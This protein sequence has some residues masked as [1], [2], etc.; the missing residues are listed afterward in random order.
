MEYGFKCQLSGSFAEN[1]KCFAPDEFD[2]IFH[3]QNVI[4]ENKY[5]SITQKVYASIDSIIRFENL[6][7]N[8]SEK[9][10][11]VSLLHKDKISC[12]HV[13]WK[14]DQLKDLNILIDVV[15]CF[16]GTYIVKSPRNINVR[17][18]DRITVSHHT[19][20]HE[21]MRS[22]PIHIK[23]G[24]ILAKAVRIASIS[25]PDN[26]ESFGLEEAVNVDDVITSFILKACLYDTNRYQSE[27]DKSKTSHDVA[28]M[29]Y[30]KLKIGLNKKQ[31]YSRHSLEY[32]VDCTECDLEYGC[33]KQRKLMLAMVEK[34][35]LSG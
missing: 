18:R 25:Q 26:L 31:V 13:L 15:V 24:F 33:C 32:P 4:N 12:I 2:F 8:D 34:I 14:G 17:S 11:I 7:A 21:M 22:L 10:Q 1:T 27:F 28:V 3:C 19:E 29:I 20:E 16:D 5:F 23:N 6:N 30:E 9:L 35:S